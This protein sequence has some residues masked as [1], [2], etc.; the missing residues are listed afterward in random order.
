[1]SAPVDVLA[2]MDS[3][4]G[5]LM[6]AQTAG[7]DTD[8]KVPELSAAIDAV[9]ELI[10]ALEISRKQMAHPH[11]CSRVR[12]TSEWAEN[13]SISFDGCQCDI[14]RVDA[15]ISRVKGGAA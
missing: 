9:A 15:A 7:V 10:E 13:G 4:L 3:S 2:V 5:D 14:R 8:T 6:A 1:M 12:P 11:G